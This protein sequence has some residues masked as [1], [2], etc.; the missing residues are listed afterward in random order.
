[1]DRKI[2]VYIWY[3]RLSPFQVGHAALTLS[4][5]THISWWPTEKTEGKKSKKCSRGVGSL[6]E[7]IRLEG[8]RPDEIFEIRISRR[9]E[10]TIK[11]W[12]I[13]FRRSGKKY[14]LSKLNCCNIVVNALE[15]GGFEFELNMISIMTPNIVAKLVARI[16]FRPRSSGELLISTMIFALDMLRTQITLYLLCYLVGVD[17]LDM[18]L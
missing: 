7:D 11:S 1:M 18:D 10:S 16:G 15:A 12:W 17:M 8:R 13:S 9:N 4:D 5:G 6:D 3:P 14:D 2:L